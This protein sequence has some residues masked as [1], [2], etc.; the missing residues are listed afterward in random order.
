MSLSGNEAKSAA[1]EAAMFDAEAY[2]ASLSEALTAA[3]TGAEVK[4]IR[5]TFTGKKSALSVASSQLGRMTPEERKAFGQIL[6]AAKQQSAALIDARE[7]EIA[8]RETEARLAA[9]AA[10][11][12]LSPYMRPR[13]TLHP[14]T[15]ATDELCAIF[16]RFGFSVAQGPEIEDEYHNF[17]ALNVPEDHPAR[18]MQDTFYMKEQPGGGHGRMLLRTHT[19]S[20]QIRALA[21][22]KPPLRIIAPGRVYRSDYDATHTPMFH[23]IEGVY[24]DKN[25]HMGHLKHCLREALAEFFGNKN[26]KMYFRPSFFPFTEPSAE[27]DIAC[28]YD[29][30]SLTVGDGDGRM[31]VLG[32]GMVHPQVLANLDIDAEEYS[33]FAFGIGIERMAMLKYGIPDLRSFFNPDKR[34]LDYYG[35]SAAS[36]PGA[37]EGVN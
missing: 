30:A 31:E 19:S 23:Q 34:W 22:K 27:V 21:G 16:A 3:H 1:P 11:V 15:R 25:V 18:E 33:G 4:D 29:K 26:L 2:I 12:S 8:A 14:V 20:V 10:D 35:F 7:A 28:T 24:I 32:C 5:V 9:D 6:N 17:T 13:G 36:V 37:A